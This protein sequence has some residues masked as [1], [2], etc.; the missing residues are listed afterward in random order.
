MPGSVLPPPFSPFAVGDLPD[1]NDSPVSHRVAYSQWG[2]PDGLP[3]L[4]FH[5]GP[6]SGSS[7]ALPRLFDPL[8]YRVVQFD[9]R[10]CGA[11]Q[12]L[13]ETRANRTELLLE[14]AERL[15][16]HLGIERWLVAGGS[17]GATLAALYAAR[18][19]ESCSA[20]LLRALFLADEAD[21][22]WFF[23]GA[24]GRY[25]E[26]WQRF[27]RELPAGDYQVRLNYLARV[28]QTG[29]VQARQRIAL[30]WLDW[31]TVL[32]GGLP[33]GTPPAGEALL[34]LINRYRIQSHYLQQRCWLAEGE[35]LAACRSLAG[36]PVVLVHGEADQVC[37]IGSAEQVRQCLPESRLHRVAGAG[38]DPFHP[39]MVQGMGHALALLRQGPGV[40]P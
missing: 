25:P 36:L 22:A 17:W 18:Y 38:H 19:R 15:R 8:I 7:A 9:Q 16:R 29:E 32:G 39:A 28:F 40:H 27:A 10:G 31:E 3:V 23:G 21:L 2:K 33:P 13:G 6:G 24:A 35:V 12:P 37:R 5:G 34:K 20:V 30:A 1:S 14:D 26:A 4:L 11:S